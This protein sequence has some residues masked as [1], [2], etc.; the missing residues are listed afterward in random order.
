[1]TTMQLSE[2]SRTIFD[3]RWSRKDADGGPTETPEETVDRVVTNVAAPTVLYGT[4]IYENDVVRIDFDSFPFR[5]ALRQARY[6]GENTSPEG[7]YAV[8]HATYE[9]YERVVA[10]YREMLLRRDFFPNSPTWTGAGTPLGQLAACFVLPIEDDLAEGRASIFETLRVAASIQQTGGGNGFAFSRLRPS[11]ALVAKS[12]G[13]ASGPVGFLYSYDAAFGWIGQ[14]GTRSGANMGVLVVHHPDIR[15]FIAAKV[16]EGHVANFNISVAITD[17]FMDAVEKDGDFALRWAPIGQSDDPVDYTVEHTIRARELYD[18]IIACAWRLGDPGSLFIDRANAFNPC[19]THYVLEATNPCGEQWLPPYS[20]CCLGSINLA[21]FVSWEPVFGDYD[22][23][24]NERWQPEFDW[25]R[26]SE[27]V[28]RAQNFLDDVVD[29]NQYV[30]VV[31]ELEA[32]AMAERRIGL[33]IMGLA[34]AMAIMGLGYDTEQGRE[35]AAQVMEYVEFHTMIASALR[36]RD[37]GPFEWFED[38]IYNAPDPVQSPGN[39]GGIVG[40]DGKVHPFWTPPTPLEP[41][42]HDFGRPRFNWADVV[43][44]IKQHGLRNACYL[45][46]APTG[47]ISN[48]ADLQGSGCEPFFALAYERMLTQHGEKVMLTYAN[49]LIAEALRRHGKSDDD[50]AAI[51]AKIKANRG[52]CRGLDEVPFDIQEAFPVAADVSPEAHVRM[53]AALQR[54]VDNSI[55]KTINMPFEATEED[56]SHVYRLAYELGCKGITIYR[57]GSRQ[58][59]VLSTGSK[60]AEPEVA[61]WPY[62]H[63]HPIPPYAY[64]D[65]L[66]SRTFPVPTPFGTA[67]VYITELREHPGRPFDVRVGFGKAGNDKL[68][69]VEAV[70]RMASIALRGGVPVE[71]VV[72][73]LQGI[74]G[75]TVV[76]FGPRRVR[77][78]ADGIAKLLRRLYMPDDAQVLTV[79]P[80]QSADEDVPAPD[81]TLICPDCHQ[82]TVVVE[83]GC[84]HC[85][86]R[87]GGCGGFTKCD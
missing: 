4:P 41:Y 84:Q 31:P 69:D 9:E 48:V 15:E 5:T 12:M 32:A 19:P 56:V 79:T 3:K 1:M 75:Q 59:E 23:K 53:Q 74:G 61:D 63:P 45:T 40:L 50:I 72:D 64:D 28:H 65:G 70:G 7:G 29:A 55:S 87:L 38:S 13:R 26:L 57:Q 2:N 46:I 22:E 82:A 73:Q 66:P 24:K 6:L 43:D 36:A 86:V 71:T 62:V 68:A 67:Q 47:T 35:F 30:P 44:L 42:T 34:D 20:N 80:R 17:E 10:E 49:P 76:G 18:E 52:S 27:V 54:F 14:G 8:S 85:D 81:P 33:G 21:N 83:S 58:M 39:M 25:A 11:K 51:A 77:S 78:V 37:R 60:T 16:E